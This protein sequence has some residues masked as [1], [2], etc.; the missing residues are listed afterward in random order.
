MVLKIILS[1]CF[2]L[3]AYV[4]FKAAEWA[5]R[6]ARWIVPDNDEEGSE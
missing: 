5:K 1:I 6:N 2:V 3:L 4:I